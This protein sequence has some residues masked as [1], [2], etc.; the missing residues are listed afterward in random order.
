MGRKPEVKSKNSKESF[1][2]GDIWRINNKVWYSERLISKVIGLC[3]KVKEAC[4]SG[5]VKNLLADDILKLL[6]YKGSE[7]DN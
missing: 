5:N 2:V 6:D 4:E 7:G 3:K 1:Q